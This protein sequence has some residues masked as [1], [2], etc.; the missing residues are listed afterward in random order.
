MFYLGEQILSQKN[1]LPYVEKKILTIGEL[2]H[3]LSTF[4]SSNFVEGSWEGISN[5]IKGYQYDEKN[6]FLYLDVGEF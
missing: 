2:I 3:F 6:G 4:P 5:E 1:K